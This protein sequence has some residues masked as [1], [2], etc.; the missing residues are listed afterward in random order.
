MLRSV[1][2]SSVVIGLAS[3]ASAA[4]NYGNFNGTTVDYLNVTE[5]S[6]TDTGALFGTP[7]LAGNSLVF[8][9]VSFGASSINGA[10]PDLTDGTLTATIA[11]KPGNFITQISIDES[12]DYTIF[13]NGT[14]A[15]SV[16]VSAPVFFQ[17]LEVNGSPIVPTTLSGS[18]TMSPSNTFSLPGSVVGGIWTGSGVF[19][20]DAH[21]AGEGIS[22][23]ATKV[24]LSLDNALLAQ[25]ETGTVAFI[26]KKTFGG[27]SLTIVP[28]PATL[29]LLAGTLLLA[30][31]RR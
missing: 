30:S 6:T 19:D 14:A 18:L 15:T 21:L 28:E 16:T 20:L 8:N 24:L 5:N 10:A 1:I 31:R 3:F 25:S 26:K 12:G 27:T 23:S 4:I 7:T 13:G 22:G 9:P 17:I 2:A 29:G 11:A